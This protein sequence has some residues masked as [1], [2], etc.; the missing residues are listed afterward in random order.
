MIKKKCKREKKGIF[1]FFL[2]KSKQK[3]KLKKKPILVNEIYI[4][5]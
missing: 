5:N 3:T 4:V 2:Y 1:F